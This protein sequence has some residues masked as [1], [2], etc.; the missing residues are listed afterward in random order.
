MLGR[1]GIDGVLAGNHYNAGE[2]AGDPRTP[3]FSKDF[4]FNK[5]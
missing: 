3:W 5:K 1:P 4:V 2:D